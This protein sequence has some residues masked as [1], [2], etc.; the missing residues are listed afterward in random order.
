MKMV[1]LHS[2]TSFLQPPHPLLLTSSLQP[3]QL[4]NL[5]RHDAVKSLYKWR[6]GECVRHE[7]RKSED[8]RQ[9][10]EVCHK[11]AFSQAI[12]QIIHQLLKTKFSLTTEQ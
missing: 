3:H 8:H 5:C 10:F 1:S 7:V 9:I 2:F 6:R 4:I 11:K 12:G